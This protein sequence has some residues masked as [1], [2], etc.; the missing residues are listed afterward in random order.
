MRRPTGKR[1]ENLAEHTIHFAAL[2]NVALPPEAD[3]FC[4]LDHQEGWLKE[5]FREVDLDYPLNLAR[6]GTECSARQFLVVTS[7]GSDTKSPNFYLQVKGE[8]ERRQRVRPP[9]AYFR[10]SFRVICAVAWPRPTCRSSGLQTCPIR[11]DRVAKEDRPIE[12]RP[13]R[14]RWLMQRCC[15]CRDLMCITL[16]RSGNCLNA[17]HNW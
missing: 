5:R 15:P 6:R 11:A 3:L 12:A 14:R 9:R 7:V 4:C 13:L 8:L 1:H 2:S 10:P 17:S 16:M